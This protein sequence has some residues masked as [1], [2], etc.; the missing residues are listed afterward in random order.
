MAFILPEA[1][2]QDGRALPSS[3]DANVTVWPYTKNGEYDLNQRTVTTRSTT[4]NACTRRFAPGQT[5]VEWNGVWYFM[6]IGVAVTI[7]N[8]VYTIMANDPGFSVS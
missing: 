7:P 3:A 2:Q 5:D 8:M 1:Q 4:I 6:P